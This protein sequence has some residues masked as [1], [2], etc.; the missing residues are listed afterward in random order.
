MPGLEEKRLGNARQ[1]TATVV[2]AISHRSGLYSAKLRADFP[3]STA[4][5]VHKLLRQYRPDRAKLDDD[6]RVPFAFVALY[7]DPC[8]CQPAKE[9]VATFV[10]QADPSQGQKRALEVLPLVFAYLDRRLNTRAEVPPGEE[11]PLDAEE[12][13]EV[14]RCCGLFLPRSG[15]R[16]PTSCQGRKR[17]PSPDRSSIRP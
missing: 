4:V 7:A 14:V 5:R 10:G 3:E 11:K 12:K 13:Q 6:L 16:G 8:D 15:N 17:P 9:V 1:W 2:K